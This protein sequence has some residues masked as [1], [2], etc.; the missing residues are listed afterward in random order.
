[1]AHAKFKS[2]F[3]RQSNV[4]GLEHIASE[5]LGDAIAVWKRG[6]ALWKESSEAHADQNFKLCADILI[7]LAGMLVEA[8][9]YDMTVTPK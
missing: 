6:A 8:A 3:I 1:M 2:K 4:V 7:G 5:N 9:G